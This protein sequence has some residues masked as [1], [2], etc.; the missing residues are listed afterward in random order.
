MTGANTSGTW[1]VN[2]TGNF[3]DLIDL[4]YDIDVNLIGGGEAIVTGLICLTIFAFLATK[5][6]MSLEASAVAFV[7]LIF[8]LSLNGYLPFWIA[9]TLV[10]LIGLILGRGFIK[11][12]R[13]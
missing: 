6:G 8:I 12:V 4:F 11:M 9:P 1:N 2:W 3:T 5:V 7:P 10:I 13:S